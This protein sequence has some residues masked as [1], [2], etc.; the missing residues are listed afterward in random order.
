MLSVS[1][2]AAATSPT[3]ELCNAVHYICQR[4]P[5]KGEEVGCL[6]TNPHLLLVEGGFQ[7]HAAAATLCQGQTAS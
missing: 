4:C 1:E 2:W 6:S 7:G 5:C 3:R